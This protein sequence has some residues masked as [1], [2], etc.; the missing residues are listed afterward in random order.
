MEDLVAP[1]DWYKIT[2]KRRDA[3]ELG[4]LDA[5]DGVLLPIDPN[6]VEIR[7]GAW[8]EVALRHILLPKL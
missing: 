6:L 1:D 7:R 3:V 2:A 8:S 4:A 5:L